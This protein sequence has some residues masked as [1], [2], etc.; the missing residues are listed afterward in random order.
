MMES[1][2]VTEPM[3]TARQKLENSQPPDSSRKQLSILRRHGGKA[4]AIA[5]ALSLL[6]GLLVIG[7]L[8]LLSQVL[9]RAIADGVPLAQL[10]PQVA[11]FAALLALRAV[12][13]F[14][15]ERAASTASEKI[16]RTLRDSL[17][18]RLLAH[19]PDWVHA[20]SSG[21]LSSAMVDQ[22]EALDG[23]F[24]RFLPATVQAAFL[25]VAFAAIAMPFDWVVG[26]LF[27]FTAPMIPLFMALVGYGAQAA[28]DAQA[29]ALSRL[30]GYFADRLRGLTTLKL[31][32][33]MEIEASAMDEATD[34]LRRRTLRVLRIAFLSSAVLEFFA[35][36][37]VAGV[38]LYVGLSYLD[39]IDMR[40]AP[41]SLQTGLFCLL[42]APEVYLPLRLLA[43][44]YHDRA[45]AEA[46]LVQIVRHF[47]EL[48]APAPQL[49]SVQRWLSLP[50]AAAAPLDIRATG[51][52]LKTPDGHST[53]L[54]SA[55][56]FIPAGR[57]LALVGPSGVGKSTL[58]Y[59][60]ARL[61]QTKGLVQLGTHRLD[62]IDERDLRRMLTL[63]CQR[64]H[65]FHG[66][67]ADNIRLADPD[68]GD[69]DIRRAA[70]RAFVTAFS[71][72]L[73]EGLGTGI[74]EGGLGL[75][76]GEAQRVALARVYLTNPS[77]ILLD[78][79]T[80]HLDSETEFKVLERL[81]D[82]A[83]RRTLV[84]ATHSPA[85]AARMDTVLLFEEGCLFAADGRRSLLPLDREFAA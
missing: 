11:G 40:F 63:V 44:H 56:L 5:I 80:A 76:G 4:L 71:D 72:T 69:E 16:K 61:G 14:A 54:A 1:S 85:V 58:L 64:P 66:T 32:G 37:G 81:Q 8:L 22:V 27:L 51:F 65:L 82:F 52:S 6:S 42:L 24:V 21:A 68:A 28:S 79:P 25:P 77:I 70:E 19:R 34:A 9:G 83:Q 13:S 46:A 57:H 12:L 47:E 45:H 36:L 67:I 23:F 26:L 35:A 50:L 75:S 33:R 59:A 30:S 43:A 39:M 84:I 74:G 10:W 20:R 38:A 3:T 31:F 55:E 48:P 15:G 53:L 73:P 2:C 29:D 7:Q 18:A 49:A 60:L 41:L 17:T 62:E 78:E